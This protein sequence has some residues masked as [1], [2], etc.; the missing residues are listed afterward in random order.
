M[1]RFRSVKRFEAAAAIVE[2]PLR[3]R[4]RHLVELIGEQGRSCDYVEVGLGVAMV[5]V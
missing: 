1:L 5:V 3:K 2:D 4:L